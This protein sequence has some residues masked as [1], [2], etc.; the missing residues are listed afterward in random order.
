MQVSMW[1]TK[2]PHCVRADERLESVAAAMEEGRFRHAPVVD[3]AGR[4]VGIV[5]H[6]DL[7]EHKGYLDKTLVNAA[8]TEPALAVG[9]DEPIEDAAQALLDRKIGALPVIDAERRVVGILTTTDLVRALLDGMGGG[10]AVRI[11]LQLDERSQGFADAVR[12]VEAAGAA[13]L[14]LGTCAGRA[15]RFFVRVPEACGARAAAALRT[16]GL[17]AALPKSGSSQA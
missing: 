7:G 9:P 1:M 14:S 3:A 4:L 15:G 10:G 13:V 8:M 5:T 2:A 16:A 17:S 12:V 11:D 6:R